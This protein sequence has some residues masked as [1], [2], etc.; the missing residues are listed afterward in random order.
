MNWL[1]DIL[2]WLAGGNKPELAG[3]K[4]EPEGVKPEPEGVDVFFS[5]EGSP[6]VVAYSSAGRALQLFL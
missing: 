3:V 5:G 1:S 4:P 2:P 6:S